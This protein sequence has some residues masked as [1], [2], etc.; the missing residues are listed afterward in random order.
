M[1]YFNSLT[2][3]GKFLYIIEKGKVF[4][5]I[6]IM[7]MPN[8]LFVYLNLDLLRYNY[9]SDLRS[10]PINFVE[11][12]N[13]SCKTTSKANSVDY[14]ADSD[15]KYDKTT[16]YW[17][18]SSPLVAYY[19]PSDQYI[20]C[21]N[22]ST[23]GMLY[24]DGY[25]LNFYTHE[26]G[27]YEYS[28]CNEEKGNVALSKVGVLGLGLGIGIPVLC[29]VVIISYFNCRSNKNKIEEEEDQELVEVDETPSKC[30]VS[31]TPIADVTT[32]TTTTFNTT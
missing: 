5:T 11:K 3:E 32:T 26:Y 15:L 2:I 31:M 23:Y 30:D 4:D 28:K 6:S 12:S 24:T 18:T 8:E 14:S 25:G 10:I 20:C 19:K 22:S 13:S 9:Y 21:Y 27:Y 16:N 7:N 1:T 17:Y 29:C